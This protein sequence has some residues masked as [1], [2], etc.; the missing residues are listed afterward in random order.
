MAI[1][2]SSH[3]HTHT[4]FFLLFSYFISCVCVCMCVHVVKQTLPGARWTIPAAREDGVPDRRWKDDQSLADPIVSECKMFLFWL[5]R[6]GQRRDSYGLLILDLPEG[7][8]EGGA[9]QMEGG[10]QC[11]PSIS[12]GRPT[13]VFSSSL[14]VR[15]NCVYTVCITG[16]MVHRRNLGRSYLLPSCLRTLPLPFCIF[17]GW[18]KPSF[19]FFFLL[20][21]SGS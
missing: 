12:I 11:P 3:I 16:A 14:I 6:M 8:W 20:L 18:N 15:P 10:A 5:V 19:L 9:R 2:T 21:S 13:R 4:L 1:H 7:D 17:F